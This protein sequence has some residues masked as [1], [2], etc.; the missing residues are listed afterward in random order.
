MGEASDH[1]DMADLGNRPVTAMNDLCQE[2]HSC[3]YGMVNSGRWADVRAK[4]FI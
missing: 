4:G 3:L 1:S 2:H